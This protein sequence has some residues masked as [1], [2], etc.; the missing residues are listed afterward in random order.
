MKQLRSKMLVDSLDELNVEVVKPKAKELVDGVNYCS[1]FDY[2][3]NRTYLS[4][5]VLKTVYKDLAKY[6]AEYILGEKEPTC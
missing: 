4:S 5:S 6:Y 3:S 1:N 2:H